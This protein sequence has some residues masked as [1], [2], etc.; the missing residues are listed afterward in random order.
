VAAPVKDV[1]STDEA[2]SSEL[3]ILA[4][5]GWV[6]R[7]L[8]VSA[9]KV[10]SLVEQ[11]KLSHP[12]KRNHEL[13]FIEDE[14]LSLVGKIHVI[15]RVSKRNEGELYSCLFSHFE[16]K[17][18]F[19]RIVILEKIS[20]DTVRSAYKEYVAGFTVQAEVSPMDTRTRA[21]LEI[22]ARR[23]RIRQTELE[24]VETRARSRETTTSAKVS[25]EKAKAHEKALESIM[26]V[27]GELRK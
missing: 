25:A 22:L 5:M 10:W 8:D 7:T 27:R 18:P 12:T 9:T 21:E 26:G 15:R 16:Q 6:T 4:T 24:I 14:V 1:V 17:T 2:K 19:A 23:E 3:E 20:P 11:G 13:I